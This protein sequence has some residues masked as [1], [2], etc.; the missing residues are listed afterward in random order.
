MRYRTILPA[1][2]LLPLTGCG[3]TSLSELRESEPVRTTENLR[4]C[5]YSVRLHHAKYGVG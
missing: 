1:V 2:L 4:R 3:I 5:R